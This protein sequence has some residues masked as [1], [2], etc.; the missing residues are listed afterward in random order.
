M[1]A[2]LIH[3]PKRATSFIA[4][5]IDDRRADRHHCGGSDGTVPSRFG[6]VRLLV[7]G[8]GQQKLALPLAR[9]VGGRYASSKGRQCGKR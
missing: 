7:V 9:P 1:M 6:V 3:V 8:T 4:E 5:N 2:K